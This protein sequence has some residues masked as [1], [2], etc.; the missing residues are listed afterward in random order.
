M[1]LQTVTIGQATYELR[2]VFQ[3]SRFLADL[4][5]EHLAQKIPDVRSVDGDDG[6]TV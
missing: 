1:E 2:R 5:A 3:G 6:H 4:M